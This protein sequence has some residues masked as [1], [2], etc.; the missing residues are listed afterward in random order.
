MENNPQAAISAAKY[1]QY[2]IKRKE[3]DVKIIATP[4][5]IMEET[6]AIENIFDDGM[7]TYIYFFIFL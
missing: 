4:E 1:F 6:E 7:Y 2:S 3:T 5:I